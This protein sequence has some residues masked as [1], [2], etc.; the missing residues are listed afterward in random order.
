MNKSIKTLYKIKIYK[1]STF[2]SNGELV[3]EKIGKESHISIISNDDKQLDGHYNPQSQLKGYPYT[4]AIKPLN[5][6]EHPSFEKI[7]KYLSST[8]W[9]RDIGYDI[10]LK[11]SIGYKEI[12]L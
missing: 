2:I 1:H 12:N 10:I 3:V 9:W 7:K 4:F 8:I 6:K 5:E 11:E